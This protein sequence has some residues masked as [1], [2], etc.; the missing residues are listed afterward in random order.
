[1][2]ADEIRKAKREIRRAV[3]ARIAAM[4]SDNRADASDTACALAR[5]ER[6]FLD[7]STVLLYLAMADEINPH[8]LLAAALDARKRVFLPRMDWDADSMQAVEIHSPEFPTEV[9]RHRLAEPV[10]TTT[11][12]PAALDLIV[13]PG[14]AFDRNGGRIGRGKGFYDRFLA[15]A[16]ERGQ[17]GDAASRPFR[18]GL[19]FSCQIVDSVPCDA[20]DQRV[21]AIASESGLTVC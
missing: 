21:D 8:P 14:V 16:R 18:L 6:H 1:M 4:T 12:D 10:G 20:H 17:A 7:A 19:C 11:I 9:R 2:D 15:R 3:R 13:V 5:A